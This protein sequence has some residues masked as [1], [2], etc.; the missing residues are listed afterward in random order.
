MNIYIYVLHIY[1]YIYVSIYLSIYL[2]IYPSI[3]IYIY[4]YI[5]IHTHNHSKT[6]W[7]Q[8]FEVPTSRIGF[9]IKI[10]AISYSQTE[11]SLNLR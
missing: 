8:E 10:G 9:I 6:S 1:I 11:E 3:Y 7:T 5:Y 4:I 2:S